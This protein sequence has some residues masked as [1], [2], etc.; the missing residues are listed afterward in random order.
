[1]LDQCFRQYYDT[2][3]EI[4]CVASM[5]IYIKTELVQWSLKWAPIGFTTP[6]LYTCRM[7]FIVSNSIPS[8]IFPG[9]C[10]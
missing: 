4:I 8:L 7:N 5:S 1:M 9:G 3:H 2:E 6:S 10:K